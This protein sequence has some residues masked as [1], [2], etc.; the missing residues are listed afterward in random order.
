MK[1]KYFSIPLTFSLLLGGGVLFS[2]Q[3]AKAQI[4]NN[5]S[6]DG[7]P[8]SDFSPPPNTSSGTQIGL[9]SDTSNQVGDTSDA[10]VNSLQ[11]E[12]PQLDVTDPQPRNDLSDF[13]ETEATEPEEQESETE[14]TEPEEAEPVR[15]LW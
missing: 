2:T 10:I 8:P 15:G 3:L 9:P 4:E 14:A 13:S 6:D 7:T 11:T 1:F 12:P 5:A